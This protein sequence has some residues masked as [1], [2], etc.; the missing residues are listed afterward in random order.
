MITRILIN[1]PAASDSIV[2]KADY[3]E[4]NALIA[5]DQ[6]YSFADYVSDVRRGGSL[7]IADEGDPNSYE[8][9]VDP[10]GEESEALANEASFELEDRLNSCDGGY[11]FVVGENYIQAKPDAYDSPYTFMLLLAVFGNTVPDQTEAPRLFEDLAGEAARSYFGGSENGIDLF[12]FG[13]PRRE[14]PKSFRDAVTELCRLLGEG[15]GVRERPTIHRQKDAKLDLAVW[16]RFPDRRI[17]QMIGFGQCATGTNWTEKLSELTPLAFC[18]SWLMSMPAVDPISMFFVPYRI[19]RTEWDV[20]ANTAGIIFDRCRIAHH[21]RDISSDL[22]DR[23]ARWSKSML[24][25][26]EG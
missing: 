11:P 6:S 22:T 5:D 10:G 4:V 14:A 26:G 20:A 3:I 23:C 17:G 9:L 16:R 25:G 19:T 18:K 2:D 13:S 24:E 8:S 15:G 7:E 12:R 21:L 1:E